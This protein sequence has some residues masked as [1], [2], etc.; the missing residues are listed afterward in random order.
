V[1]KRILVSKLTF[2]SIQDYSKN[3]GHHIKVMTF[4]VQ[5]NYLYRF[6]I[7]WRVPVIDEFE[8]LK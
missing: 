5:S 6:I 3:K 1:R 2:S 7:T 4:L 8:I